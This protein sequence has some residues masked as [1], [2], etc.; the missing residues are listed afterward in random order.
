MKKPINIRIQQDAHEFV[1]SF[2]DKLEPYFKKN[3][4]LDEFNN[5]FGG[6]TLTQFTCD[7][8]SNKIQRD[9]S[10]I[11]LSLEVKNIK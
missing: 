3:N 8:C 7:N 2:F 5:I 6:K 4:K 1:S 11:Q 10:F 9:E